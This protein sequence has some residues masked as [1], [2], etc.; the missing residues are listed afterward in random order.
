MPR[1]VGW[2]LAVAL[3]PCLP[4]FRRRMRHLGLAT[5]IA[6]PVVAVPIPVEAQA[7]H[8]KGNPDTGCSGTQQPVVC[9][10]VE[11]GV[12]QSGHCK[13]VG[14]V[15]HELDC[16]CV[17]TAAPPP[18][19]PC[20]DRT[21]MGL[22]SCTIMQ[23]DVTQHETV[24]P[25]I[26]FAPG[27]VVWVQADGCVQ[28][29]GVG[30]TWK[31]YVNP[32][33]DHP[34]QKYHGLIRIPTAE[35][36]GS[37]LVPIQSV[38]GRLQTVAG[39]GVDVSQLV[40]HL[41]YEDDD[42]SDNGYSNHDDGDDDQCKIGGSND[43]RPAYVIVNIYRGKVRRDI[44]LSRFPF[45]VISTLIDRNGS[46]QW[47]PNGLPLNPLWSWQLQSGNQGNTPSEDL[48]HKFTK[49]G[50]VLDT[51]VQPPILR[52]A[53]VP[54]FPDCTDQ[55]DLNNVDQPSGVNAAACFLYKHDLLLRE[56][57]IGHVNWFPLTVEGHAGKPNH[58][59]VDDDYTFTFIIDTKVKPLS[60]NGSDA[61]HV[62]FDSDETID[63]FKSDEWVA[64]H[65]A[66][67][68][69]GDALKLFAGQ[70]IL[71]GMFGLDG[72]HELKAE[73]HPLYAIATELDANNSPQD[74]DWLMFV[75]NR[76]DEGFCSSS[77]WDAGFEDY[78]FHLKWRDG[79]T[80]VNVNWSK[81]QFEGTDGTS[82]PTIGKILP[83]DTAGDTAGVYVT[84][85]LGPAGSAPFRDGA[86]HLIWTG[87]RI[88]QPKPLETSGDASIEE[89]DEIEQAVGAAVNQLPAEQLREIEKALPANERPVVR[90]APLAGG[91]IPVLTTP[92][93]VR[94][95]P[96]RAINAGPATV[97]MKRDAALMHAL[98]AVTHGA[99]AGLPKEIC[100]GNMRDQ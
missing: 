33:G 86:L 66:V 44:P 79:M 36:V 63:N 65:R 7:T 59:I 27:D 75:R 17:G 99:P 38:I 92:P 68:G 46:P 95:A 57:F 31:R 98:C 25:N 82:G 13:T 8:C 32:W 20:R 48:C 1:V 19:D 9:S 45:D 53:T 6:V 18:P 73:L 89:A 42:Y 84:F 30:A 77:L 58:E 51:R 55:T 47:D 24:Y 72:E 10:P 100:S 2:G 85:H 15:A 21:A 22:I 56:S 16:A 71:T 35:P 50:L 4:G 54:S 70:A 12:G 14:K 34:D 60:V 87:P 28:T 67:D 39:A 29:G 81:T 69:D 37:G 74:D 61:L 3:G 52:P 78:T 41:G 97:K 11:V 43:G 23:P 96:L 62:E 90:T 76:G 5:A 40:L 88:A 80:D 93:S 26:A 49:V 83:S 64:L 91:A 94:I